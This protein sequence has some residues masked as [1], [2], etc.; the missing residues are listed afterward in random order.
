M[1]SSLVHKFVYEPTRTPS[2][3]GSGKRDAFP[4]FSGQEFV[5]PS[6]AKQAHGDLGPREGKGM[7][8]L[9][10]MTAVSVTFFTRVRPFRFLSFTRTHGFR[11]R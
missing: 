10:S 9:L 5:L 8:R 3:I 7:L 11:S 2:F 1:H 4:L 6:S